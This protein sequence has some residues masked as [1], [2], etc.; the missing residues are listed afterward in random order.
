[1]LQMTQELAEEL[2][3]YDLTEQKELLDAKSSL[4]NTKYDKE[5]RDFSRI[6]INYALIAG[7]LALAHKYPKTQC[8][9]SQFMNAFSIF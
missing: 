1:M 2:K 6:M 4:Y 9:K 7:K 8:F 5:H 3:D